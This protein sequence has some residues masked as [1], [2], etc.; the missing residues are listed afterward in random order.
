M[1]YLVN[2][3]N[4]R[5]T[6]FGIKVDRATAALPATA[7][8]AIYTIAGG[9]ILLV[10]LVGEVTTIMG[11]T[12]T[13][14]KV[15]ANPTTGLDVDLTSA[16]AV[17]SREVGALFTLPLTLGGALTVNNAGAGQLP[18]GAYVVPIGTIDLVTSATDTGSVKWSLLYAP[19]D[20]G[21]TVVAA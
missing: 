9:R 8:T 5:N 7:Q 18:A 14:L 20:D 13:T 16:T 17:T 21:A 3:N 10:G 4:V 6:V 11:A 12:V 15:T 19:L 2:P 1:S